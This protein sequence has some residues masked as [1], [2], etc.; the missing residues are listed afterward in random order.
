MLKFT[1]VHRF[2]LAVGVPLLFLAA[3][4]AVVVGGAWERRAAADQ[5]SLGVTLVRAASD[6]VH[7]L[8]V[9]RGASAG[10]I[11]AQ[12]ADEFAQRLTKARAGSDAAARIFLQKLDDYREAGGPAVVET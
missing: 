5:A 6:L 7:A 12:G 10:F 1:I 11:G 2:A 8:Q 9:E 3:F 4:A